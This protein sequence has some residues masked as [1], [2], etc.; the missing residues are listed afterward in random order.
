[1]K[2][3]YTADNP[4]S[5]QLL[6]GILEQSGIK[7]VIQGEHGFSMRGVFS[8]GVMAGPTVWVADA[9]ESK[10]LEIIRGFKDSAETP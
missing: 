9:D 3:V 6:K 5:A 8:G 4:A 10:A 2:N 7:A 1:M